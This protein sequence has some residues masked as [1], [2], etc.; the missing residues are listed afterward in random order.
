[1]VAIPSVVIEASGVVVEDTDVVETS[2]V[3]V[4]ASDVV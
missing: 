1:M 4:E 2:A 3:V